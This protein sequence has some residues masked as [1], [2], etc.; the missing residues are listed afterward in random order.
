MNSTFLLIILIV[1][2]LSF[3][4]LNGFHDSANLV[5]TMISSRAMQPRGAL[6]MAA[7]AVFAGPFLFGVAVATTIGTI[8]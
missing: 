3:D 8:P 7:V 1:L 5:A 4:F 2:A 6:L